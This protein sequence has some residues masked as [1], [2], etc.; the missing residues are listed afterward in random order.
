MRVVFL[1]RDGV[2]NEYPGDR[3]YVTSWEEFNFIP[4]SIEAI[5][6]LRNHKFKI[7][8]ASNQAGVAKGLYSHDDIERINKNM[9]EAIRRQG[10][11]LDGIHYCFHRDEDN[12]SCRKP[13]PGLLTKV[14]DN[15]QKKPD[16][17]FFIGDSLRDVKAA[18]SA[19]CESVLVFSGKEKQENK[20]SWD[21]N[22]DYV[23]ANLLEAARYICANYE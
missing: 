22:P 5:R 17:S 11:D 7:F 19:G 21:I 13:K 10:G 16:A 14:L 20:P 15:L 6:L 9:L 4:G 18:K 1:D 23:F 8:V 12:C 2:I 3:N